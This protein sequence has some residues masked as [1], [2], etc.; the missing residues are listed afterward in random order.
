MANANTQAPAGTGLDGSKSSAQGEIVSTILSFF[1]WRESLPGTSRR[2]AQ[3]VRSL[4]LEAEPEQSSRF[5]Y[6]EQVRCTCCLGV[7]IH[8]FHP[9]QQ[10]RI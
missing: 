8:F 4:K 10:G 1:C 9:N 5:E 3:F 6:P 7:M 2:E